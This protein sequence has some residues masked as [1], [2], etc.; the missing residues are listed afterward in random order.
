MKPPSLPCIAAAVLLSVASGFAVKACSS[1]ELVETAGEK[2]EWSMLQAIELQARDE[3]LGEPAVR[4]IFD[5][6]VLGVSGASGKNI[7]ILLKASP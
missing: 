2:S 4:K 6:E 3:A 5:A 1:P 7:W